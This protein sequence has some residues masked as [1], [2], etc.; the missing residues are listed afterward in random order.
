VVLADAERVYAE[1]V[2]VHAFRNYVADDLPLR[3]RTAVRSEGE[4]A[5]GIEAEL[6]LCHAASRG[7]AEVF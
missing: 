2:G 7:G 5:E 3:L 6:K 4:V 1:R